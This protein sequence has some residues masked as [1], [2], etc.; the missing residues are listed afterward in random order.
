MHINILDSVHCQASRDLI[1]YLKEV[2]K[3]PSPYYKEMQYGKKRIE[4]DAF[5]IDKK[6]MF[7]TGFLPRIKHSLAEQGIKAEINGNLVKLRPET[8]APYIKG[9]VLRP[10]QIELNRKVVLHQRGIVLSPTGS[11][12]TFLILSILSRFP[13]A[14]A[15]ILCNLL[16]IAR[17]TRD[18]LTKYGY[19]DVKLIDADGKTHGKITVGMA[20]SVAGIDPREY[21]DRY[22]I[23]I[24]D[25]F[26]HC[27][28]LNGQY[29]RIFMQSAA[30]IK[31]G[32]TATLPPDEKRRMIMEGCAGQVIGE[33]TIE[34]GIEKGFLAKPR[35]VLLAPPPI[36]NLNDYRTYEK[37]YER[38][39]VLNEER[40][41]MI[42]EAAQQYVNEGKT[43]LIF[44]V[45]IGHGDY[46]M[47]IANDIGFPMTF[48]RGTTP[49]EVRDEIKKAVGNKQ[50]KCIIATAVFKEGVNIPSLDVVING[51]GGQSEILTIQYVGRGLRVTE[52][53]DEVY[54]VDFL[55]TGRFLADHAVKRLRIYRSNGWL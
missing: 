33:V 31:I 2:L 25:E 21:V 24:G 55:D 11:G 18:E 35:I 49:V 27:S 22:D 47:D 50:I 32:L 38:A 1:P 17:Q 54:I 42:V 40:N 16:S 37:I 51:A 41:V 5:L 45:K 7:L 6:G 8:A 15:L 44:V 53:K 14:S 43:V 3:Y 26:H 46:L 29:A 20:P 19:K 48:V 4:R 36:P 9:E 12:K 13:S 52:E 30:P 34:E 39:V 23:L 28:D 10:D